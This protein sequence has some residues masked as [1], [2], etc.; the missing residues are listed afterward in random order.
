MFANVVQTQLSDSGLEN[1]GGLGEGFEEF[2]GY[3]TDMLCPVDPISYAGKCEGLFT[4]FT[5]FTK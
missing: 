1:K 2:S 4:I 3:D 5:L